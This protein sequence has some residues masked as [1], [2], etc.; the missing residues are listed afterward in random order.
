M[1]EVFTSWKEIAR[2]FGKGVRTVQRWE[3]EL[4]LPVRRFEAQAERRVLAVPEE[5][6]QWVM[7]RYTQNGSGLQAELARCR[8]EVAEL[9]AENESLRK[10]VESL[11]ARVSE[12]RRELLES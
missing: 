9:S 6:D 12:L 2:Y 5:L 11:R 8:S 7:S 3:R 4:G 1:A 10:E